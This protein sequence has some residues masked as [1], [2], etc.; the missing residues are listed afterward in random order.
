MSLRFV[1]LTI[2]VRSIGSRILFYVLLVCLTKFVI[3]VSV[4]RFFGSFLIRFRLSIVTECFFVF[5]RILFVLSGGGRLSCL[6]VFMRRGRNL[7]V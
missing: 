7:I 6:C 1:I 4:I 2:F 5:V 3:G